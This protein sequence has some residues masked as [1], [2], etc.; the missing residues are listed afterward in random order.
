MASAENRLRLEHA[1]R[2]QLMAL[3]NGFERT[4]REA[5]EPSMMAAQLVAEECMQMAS[6][7]V[8]HGTQVSAQEF[9]AECAR[10]L[11]WHREHPPEVPKPSSLN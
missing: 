1:F 6:Y 10:K 4:V 2:D 7:F 5:G 11:L 9:A 3:V 8:A